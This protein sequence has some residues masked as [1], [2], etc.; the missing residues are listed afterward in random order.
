[1]KRIFKILSYYDCFDIS[2]NFVMEDS[3]MINYSYID[4]YSIKLKKDNYILCDL[5][6][7]KFKPSFFDYSL[8][9]YESFL[10]EEKLIEYF[11]LPQSIE[12]IKNIG[13]IDIHFLINALILFFEIENP[14]L[15]SNPLKLIDGIN[16]I[17]ENLEID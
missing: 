17:K 7:G 2:V 15:V 11:N 1:M 5:N 3:L 6:E 14:D 12:E 8:E 13:W 9:G 16:N 10:R 4:K